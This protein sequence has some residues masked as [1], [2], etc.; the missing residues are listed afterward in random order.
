M[1]IWLRTALS[2][3]VSGALI[4]A[5]IL[6]AVRLFGK[7]LGRRWQYYVWLLVAVRLVLPAAVPVNLVG[8]L[9]E[10]YGD[11]AGALTVAGRE[12]VNGAAGE[13]A[14][15]GAVGNGVVLDGPGLSGEGIM[16]DSSES[17]RSDEDG[18]VRKQI[19]SEPA[20]PNQDAA[21]SGGGG[22]SAGMV[23]ASA[24]IM[25][26]AVAA[27]LFLYKIYHYTRAV[28]QLR[29]GCGETEAYRAS[30]D[31][32]CAVLEMKR[33]PVILVSPGLP[34]P[35]A[36]GVLHPAIVMPPDIPGD[37]VYHMLLHE[38]TH[39]RRY[40]AVYKWVVE[41]LVCLHWFNPMVYVLRRETARACE[42]SCDEAVISRLDETNRRIYGRMLLETVRRSMMPGRT[43]LTLTLGGNAKWMKE[44]LG[45]IMDYRKKK[46]GYVCAAL[47]LTA[48][49]AGSALLCGFAPA[50]QGS[51]A[52][53]TG[54][55]VSGGFLQTSRT[56]LEKNAGKLPENKQDKV[57]WDSEDIRRR[58]DQKGYQSE[59]FWES[60]YI[61]ALAWNVDSQQY[62]IVRQID[63]RTVCFTNKTA[64]YADDSDIAKAI[65]LAIAKREEWGK[66]QPEELVCLGLDG[67]FE[68][69]ADQLA[70][71]FYEED[72][73]TNFAAV[74]REAG[75]QTCEAM[76]QKSYTDD[77]V[78]YFTLTMGGK[79]SISQ[80]SLAA[81]AK[82]AAQD[83]KV[84]FFYI[85]V[86]D[87][88]DS[89][90]G[91][92]AEDAY[93]GNHIDI[94]YAVSS[95]LSD[96]QAGEL[97]VKAYEDGRI[98]F[99]YALMDKLTET[100]RTEL[101]ERAKKDGKTEF[102]YALY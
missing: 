66:L 13:E 26:L 23:S 16:P 31:R 4:A 69:T 51:M 99:F 64:A 3:S 10:R 98:E 32:A 100:Q 56:I 75:A 92:F 47:V 36:V 15:Y 102:W 20:I 82:K 53:A 2:L 94:F 91:E 11:N 21:V 39:V 1:S 46:K 5:V 90:L 27:A 33:K 77:R 28:H 79:G 34:S 61:M 8:A 70:Q 25:W 60:G 54:A 37:S 22:R 76:I 45:D 18:S 71:R 95:A 73:M 96:K 68:G 97:A 35:I 49:L 9:F 29:S 84:E 78:E 101:R 59:M 19:Q 41:I 80:D 44:R 74:I 63:G 67:P 62:N 17:V 83:G 85:A 42:L 6:A 14:A 52:A 87:L 50:G 48:A 86:E 30:F 24:A 7:R 65:G 12:R 72:N 38:L 81:I 57:S 43:V 58:S 88:P 89:V 93:N 40:D 55:S